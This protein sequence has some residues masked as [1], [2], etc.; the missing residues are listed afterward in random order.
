MSDRIGVMRGG[1]LAA[2]LPGGAGATQVMSAAL[3][4][5]VEGTAA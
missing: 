1:E 3:G 2:E 4:Q 5:P